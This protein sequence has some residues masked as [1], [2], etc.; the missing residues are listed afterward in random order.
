MKRLSLCMAIFVLACS[1][2]GSGLDRKA[3]EA[4]ALL[5]IGKHAAALEIYR[6]IA[7]HCPSYEG[8]AGALIRIGDIEAD[9]RGKPDEAV[10]A[11]SRAVEL[12]PTKEAARI[13]LERRARIYEIIG[14]NRKA[15]SD[16]ARLLQYFTESEKY[17]L[18][19]LRLGESYLTMKDYK[20]ARLELRG[21]IRSEE[22]DPKIGQEALFAY[23]ESFFLEGRLGLAEKAYRLLVERYPDSPLVTEAN[24]KIATC[25]EER[26][27]LGDAKRSL[28]GIEKEYP[29][30]PVVDSRLDAIDKRGKEA[31]PEDVMRF[32][33]RAEKAEEE[34]KEGTE[35]GKKRE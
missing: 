1:C 25:Q 23:A 3:S 13:A 26:G 4:E 30:V 27:F 7:E 22:V 9:M 24:M 31:P 12:F 34:E 20:Q 28:K 19:L 5:G 35:K 14:D 2:S 15:A 32:V 18:Y 17:P 33:K 29:N 16:Y 6:D 10:R 21:L 8:C 11:Y